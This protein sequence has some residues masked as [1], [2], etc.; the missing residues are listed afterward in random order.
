MVIIVATLHRTMQYVEYMK[1]HFGS[2]S[3][4]NNGVFGLQRYFGENSPF[5]C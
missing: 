5:T 2:V 1:P 4:K 3:P